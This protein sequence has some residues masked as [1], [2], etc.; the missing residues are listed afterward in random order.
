M[1]SSEANLTISGLFGIITVSE[2]RYGLLAQIR[3]GGKTM[4]HKK[5]AHQKQSNT[6]AAN[7]PSKAPSGNLIHQS[8]IIARGVSSKHSTHPI[9][10]IVYCEGQ[11]VMIC[12]DFKSVGNGRICCTYGYDRTLC[13]SL[14][15]YKN[16]TQEQ[17]EMEAY[18][19][20]MT[21]AR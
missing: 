20:W 13:N 15:E 1:L 19:A 11:R 2:K 9:S 16:L 12:S 17:I 5:Q 21:G 10:Y 3:I 6:N 4:S 14:E 7:D 8:G 18:Q